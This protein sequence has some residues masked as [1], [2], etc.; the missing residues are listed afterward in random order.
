[1]LVGDLNALYDP[2]DQF[3]D[4]VKESQEFFQNASREWFRNLIVKEKVLVDTFR[5]I[6]PAA[7]RAFTC[8]NQY[9]NL[10]PVNQGARLDYILV[11]QGLSSKI[12]GA[13]HLTEMMGSDHC[14]VVAELDLEPTGQRDPP[15]LC[16]RYWI[17][18]AQP[19]VSSFF[20]KKREIEDAPFVG[21]IAPRKKEKKQ[22][23]LGDF[24]STV[25]SD[26]GGYFP[27]RMEE[28]E[29]P[30]IATPHD[31]ETRSE[32]EPKEITLA[33]AQIMKPKPIPKCHHQQECKE[34]KAKVKG[35]NQGR[36]FYACARPGIST[37]KNPIGE[38]RCNFF[39][40]KNGPSLQSR[41][42]S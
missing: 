24:F 18:L 15:A 31:Q 27:C 10:R 22:R 5:Y 13:S 17:E 29:S 3:D 19:K 30:K 37:T 16:S 1:M 21:H 11:S 20:T 2:R 7:E 25:S 42:I 33:W 6:H 4:S 14:P 41:Q 32:K 28:V 40:W 38:E 9:L 12:L 26:V 39:K 8:W 36:T 35:P 34:F 23:R